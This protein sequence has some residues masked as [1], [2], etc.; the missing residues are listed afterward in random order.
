MM[1]DSDEQKPWM[2]R[3]WERR[4]GGIANDADDAR[5][6]GMERFTAQEILDSGG[7][8]TP[9]QRANFDLALPYIR[10]KSEELGMEMPEVRVAK[11]GASSVAGYNRI[12]ISARDLQLDWDRLEVRLTHELM[13]LKN[14]DMLRGDDGE[15]MG[16]GGETLGAPD[17]TFRRRREFIADYDAAAALD[18]PRGLRRALIADA[19]EQVEYVKNTDR[20]LPALWDELRTSAP[21]GPPSIRERIRQARQREQDLG[22]KGRR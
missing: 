19:R 11:S 13:H 7:R 18:D 2:T 4:H 10:R 14:K 6:P 5:N 16:P 21:H 17:P 8:L 20:D 12:T 15:F 3:E 22:D 1:S 9:E